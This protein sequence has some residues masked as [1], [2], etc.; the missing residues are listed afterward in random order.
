MKV[1][2][3]CIEGCRGDDRVKGKVVY[4]IKVIINLRVG[5]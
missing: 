2:R 1:L 3:C 5:I 4:F